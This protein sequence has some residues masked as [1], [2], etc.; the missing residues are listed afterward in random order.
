MDKTRFEQKY[1]LTEEQIMVRDLAHDFAQ[2]EIMPVIE[3]LDHHGYELGYTLLRKT[4]ELG[5]LGI[6]MPEEYGGMGLDSISQMLMM[7]EIS[8]ASASFGAIMQAH[9]G[10]GLYAILA[11]GT[12]D[13]K[14]KWLA[15]AIA[16]EKL[17]SFALTEPGSGSDSGSLKTFAR[18]DGDEW[19]LNGCKSWIS[20]F[21]SGGFFVVAAKTDMNA[22]R[23]HGISIF[24]V[25]SGTPGLSLGAP[26]R[27][28][29][30]RAQASGNVYFDDCRIPAD[31]LI[32]EEGEG[33]KAMM[34]GIDMGRLGIAA[35]SLGIAQDCYDRTVRYTNERETFGK[36]L[37][38]H[39]VIS[40]YLAEMAA[41]I[42]I[43][44]N[45]LYNVCRMK[46]AGLD[47]IAEAAAVKVFA[48]EMCVRI[49]EKCLQ[50]HGGNG[51]SE[52]YGIERHWR[53]SKLQTIGEGTTE[54]CKIVMARRCVKGE[55]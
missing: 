24:C 41:E 17:C 3:E 48:S 46:D 33:F 14:Q 42:D 35:I 30:D 52:E 23:G 53:D 37:C 54:I 38:E 18:K 44:R 9:S 19:V 43:A 26:E 7:E 47:Y 22:R 16:G 10:L 13:Q 21:T 4:A 12:E 27:K 31:A 49:S 36:K 34:K 45:M 1:F 51:Y 2:K 6:A 50:M 39:Q 20:N 32:G 25:E 28:C 15:P 55:Y 8:K 29:G 5:F 40:F 11:G